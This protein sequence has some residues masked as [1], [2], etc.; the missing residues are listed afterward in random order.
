MML[1]MVAIGEES[2]ALDSMLEKV[3]THYEAEVD[4]AVDNL[5]ALMEPLI[6]SVLGVL[7][8]GL[9]VAMYMPIF[10]LGNAI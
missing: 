8:G 7:V 2:G 1:Q 4:N 3:A 6:M 9:M 5:T 10:Q